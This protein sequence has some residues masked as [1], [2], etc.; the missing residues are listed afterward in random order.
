MFMSIALSLHV[1]AIVVWVGGMFFAHQALRPAA[2]STLEP[3]LRLQLWV[4]TFKRFFPWVWVCVVLVLATGLWMMLQFPKAPIFVHAMLGLGIVMM[5]IFMHVFF[6]PYNRL[7]KAV[8]E[9]RW[10]DGGNALG[11]IRTMVGINTVIGIVTIIIATA[12]KFFIQ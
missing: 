9:Q 5:L 1:L 2:V 6:A 3:P 8:A 12:G 4:A 11:Q 7:K 10:P